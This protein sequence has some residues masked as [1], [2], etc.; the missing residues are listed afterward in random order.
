[1]STGTKGSF[2]V[3]G[4]TPQN[5]TNQVIKY[6]SSNTAVMT[7]DEKGNFEA[8][9]VGEATLK[10]EATDGSGKFVEHTVTVKPVLDN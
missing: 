2:A 10:A 5:A 1:M 4:V 6:S 9:G 7:I 8:V 3:I